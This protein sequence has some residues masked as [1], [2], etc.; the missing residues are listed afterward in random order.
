MLIVNQNHTGKV[1]IPQRGS[2][3]HLEGFL[4]NQVH[5]LLI[6]V[7]LCRENLHPTEGVLEYQI[8]GTRESC[9][10]ATLNL[11]DK[12]LV[13]PCDIEG[14]AYNTDPLSY[15]ATI[16][17]QLAESDLSSLPRLGFCRNN[18]LLKQVMLTCGVVQV[19]H[20]RKRR[21]PSPCSGQCL[22]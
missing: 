18:H 13:K 3:G 6:E 16:K 15:L 10:L 14:G 4:H 22:L 17:V 9:L 19:E 8:P 1:I 21:V 11:G 12:V 5:H 7:L 20:G 2:N